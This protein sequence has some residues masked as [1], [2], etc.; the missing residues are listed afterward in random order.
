MSPKNLWTRL[1]KSLLHNSNGEASNRYRILRRNIF[2]LMILITIIPLIIMAGIYQHEY[3]SSIKKEI[4]NPLKTLANKTKHSLEL[5]LE[6]RL[7]VIRFI[8]ASYSFEELS[9]QKT[10]NRIFNVLMDEYCCLVD[11]GL[12]NK[13]GI[14]LSYVGPYEFLGKNYSKQSWFHEV[15]VKGNYISDVFMG[16]RQFPH[17]AIAVLRRTEEGRYLILRATIDTS[18]FDNII[19]SM[20]LDQESDAFLINREGFLQTPSRFYGK[21]LDKYPVSFPM[22]NYGPIVVEEVDPQKRIMLIVY[23]PFTRS[24]YIM[25]LTKQRSALL[26]PWYTLKTKM[27]IIFA[28]SVITIVLIVFKLTDTLVKRVKDADEK[29]ELAYKEVQHTHKLSSIGR[30]AAG[31]AHEINNPLA[32]INEK[33]GLMKDLV[34]Y[35]DQFWKNEKFLGLTDSILKSVERCKEITHRLLGFARRMEVQL[36]KLDLN[37]LIQETLSFL[38]KEALYRNIVLKLQLTDNLPYIVSD[39]GQLQQ[40]FLNILSNAFAAVEDGGEVVVTSWEEDLDTLGVSIQDNGSGMSEEI[41]RNIFDPFFTT[42]QKGG[43][44]LGLAIT[45]GIVKKMGGE[46]KVKSKQGEGSIFTVYLPKKAKIGP[47]E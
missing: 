8:A 24:D 45:Y 1:T 41:L 26:K 16:Y 10:L 23:V 44:G 32:I 37:E 18:K 30:L 11:L 15:V 33:A 27:L 40:V 13:K 17:V 7:S 34:A 22:G 20:Q 3:Q 12:I 2:I 47:G 9:D 19:A 35:D 4:V 46:I 6:E 39:R 14:Q 28:I 31:V 21:I 43:T 42:K 38:N 25:V 5:F 29:R 36:V